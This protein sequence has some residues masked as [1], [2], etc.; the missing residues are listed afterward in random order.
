MSEQAPRAIEG[1]SR[2]AGRFASA[3]SNRLA[4]A[5]ADRAARGLPPPIDL[6]AANPADCGLAIPPDL[7]ERAYAK[8]LEGKGRRYAPD[9]L[10][11]GELRE[12]IAEWYAIRGVEVSPERVVVAPGTSL[13]YFHL[14][15]LLCDAG[16]A[17]VRPQPSYPLLDEIARIAEV[18]LRD[19]PLR[20]F[21]GWALDPEA[22]ES[23]LA[24]GRERMIA[25]VSPH[26]PTG[27][28]ATR[29]QLRGLGRVADRHGLAL[30]FD[31]VF[32]EFL[33]EPIDGETSLPRPRA[34][35]GFPAF[36]LL[37]GLSKAHGLPGHKIG[38]IAADG[39]DARRVDASM[40]ALAHLSDAFL[41]ASDVAQLAAAELLRD[42]NAGGPVRDAVREIAATLTRRRSVLLRALGI[43]DDGAGGATAGGGA[44]DCALPSGGTYL[45][46]RLVAPGL[47]EEG[48][49]LRLLERE[50]L[51]VH[52]GHF[53]DIPGDHL[54]LTFLRDDATLERAGEAIAGLVAEAL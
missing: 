33:H 39:A 28:V 21:D 11:R 25:L 49:A 29:G 26:N 17:V 54:V 35:D 46:L 16:D 53:Y 41:G 5:L 22:V 30:A 44:I 7:V 19:F 2:L 24:T 23:A 14:F 15:R 18:E 20:E 38:W 47:E 4:K 43:A 12:A 13:G 10:G 3:K 32:S 31:E 8:A 6:T 45:T 40:R 42:E 34:E 37:N 52:P 1:L 27:A 48:L 9:P 51:L 50:G 36:F